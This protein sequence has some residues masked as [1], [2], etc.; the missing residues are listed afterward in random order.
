MEKAILRHYAKQA[1]S[2]EWFLNVKA[3]LST[4]KGLIHDDCKTSRRLRPRFVPSS[5]CQRWPHLY[6]FNLLFP[7]DQG[8]E[9]RLNI[10]KIKIKENFKDEIT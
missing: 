5:N 6:T 8:Q 7:A 1:L 2:F 9:G 3:L 10:Y 4:N